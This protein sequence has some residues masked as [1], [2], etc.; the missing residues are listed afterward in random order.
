[1]FIDLVRAWKPEGIMGSNQRL[2]QTPRKSLPKGRAPP[3][4]Y[5]E[6]AP[7]FVAIVISIVVA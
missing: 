1:M 2:V 3:G 7:L 5:F 4:K 6:R